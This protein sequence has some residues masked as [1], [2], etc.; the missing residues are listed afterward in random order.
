MMLWLYLHLYQFSSKQ[1]VI[2]EF[3]FTMMR[4]SMKRLSVVEL[5]KYIPYN[6]RIIHY[7]C[8]FEYFTPLFLA[9]DFEDFVLHELYY[10][11]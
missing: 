7:R 6:V 5:A 8:D 11:F 9:S 2:Y 4:I 10:H 3:I 1:S